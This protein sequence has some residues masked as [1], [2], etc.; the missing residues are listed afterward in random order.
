MT[1]AFVGELREWATRPPAVEARPLSD[2]PM[3]PPPLPVLPAQGLPE[4]RLSEARLPFLQHATLCERLVLGIAGEAPFSDMPADLF[5]EEQLSLPV[6]RYLLFAD[7]AATTEW[8]GEDLFA[9]ML[10]AYRVSERV[11]MLRQACYENGKDPAVTA[12]GVTSLIELW[13]FF[14]EPAQQKWLVPGLNWW[15][16]GLV[17]PLAIVRDAEVGIALKV[18]GAPASLTLLAAHTLGAGLAV[19]EADIRG[20]NAADLLNT[21]GL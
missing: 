13:E 4:V 21:E 1:A 8:V 11:S 2:H 16:G 18:E 15:M 17:M 7:V 9:L 12:A 5:D 14:G 10:A 6:L 20:V 3:M 19:V